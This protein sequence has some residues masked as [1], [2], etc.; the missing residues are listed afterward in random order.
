[1]IVGTRR[2]TPMYSKNLTCS[3]ISVFQIIRDL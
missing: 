2:M 1:M 3:Y